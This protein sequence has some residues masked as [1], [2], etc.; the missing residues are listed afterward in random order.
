M[1]MQRD[2]QRLETIYVVTM[3]SGGRPGRRWKTI[4]RPKLLPSGTGVSFISLGTKLSVHVIGNISV[5]EFEQGREYTNL[6]ED[7]D[8]YEP[9]RPPQPST[10]VIA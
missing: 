5:E 9:K 10:P 1:E 6:D 8:S 3:W 4:E 2:M 7:E